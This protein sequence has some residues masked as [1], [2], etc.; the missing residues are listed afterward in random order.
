MLALTREAIAAVVPVER[1]HYIGFSHHE[2]DEDGA[3][4]DLLALAPHAVPLCGRINAMVNADAFDRPPRA[5]A[6]GEALSLGART[7]RWIDAPHVP[8]AWDCGHLFEATTRTLLCGDLFT[9]PGT[10]ET[11][12]TEDDILGPSEALRTALDYFAHAPSTRAV[13][14]RIAK[15]EPATLACMHGS[16][17][18]G[19]GAALLRALAERIA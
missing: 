15:E 10:G 16:A 7:V 19:D 2:N 13:L 11:P 8:H 3:L 6:D 5:L 12:L 14:Q 1:L 9:Q 18:A 4:N 17:W